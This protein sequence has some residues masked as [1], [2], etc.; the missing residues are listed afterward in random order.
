RD[1]AADRADPRLGFDHRLHRRPRARDARTPEHLVR[2]LAARRHD[3]DHRVSRVR[4]D[5][6]S[7]LRV[8]RRR[9]G[10]RGADLAP[11]HRARARR[12]DRRP[13][14]RASRSPDRRAGSS[15]PVTMRPTLRALIVFLAGIPLSLSAVA[16]S[17]RLWTMW[18]AYLGAAF[19]LLGA[20]LVLS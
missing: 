20:D 7:R 10:A 17:P 15:A 12:R 3:A 8:A 18:L 16:I 5:A 14:R 2:R 9:Q 6:G 19:L 11:S 1:A 13:D 4:R